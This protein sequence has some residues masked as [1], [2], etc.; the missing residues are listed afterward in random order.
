MKK[1]K[2]IVIAILTSILLW[3][4]LSL[5]SHRLFKPG[6]CEHTLKVMTYN[7]HGMMIG[8]TLSAQKEM[9]KYINTQNADIVCLQEVLV[10]NDPKLLTLETL[11]GAMS[12]Y[13][14]SYCDFKFSNNKR[15]FG[16]VIFSRYPLINQQRIP[17][18]SKSNIS[19]QCDVVVGKDTIRLIVNH[20]ESYKL[21][22]KDMKL[23]E[24]LSNSPVVQKVQDSDLLRHRQ[25]KE[26][27]RHIRKS[28]HPVIVVGDFNAIPLS[29]VYWKI[30]FGLHDCFLNGSFGK[31]GN[32]YRRGM[33]G[34]RIDFI[35]CSRDLTPIDCIV[36]GVNYSDHLPVI[37]TIGW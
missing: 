18:E 26:V 22:K 17:Y 15:Q 33:F 5:V 24:E 28:P 8:E 6:K 11:H 29:L 1:I 27:K 14:Y 31:L 32:T 23:A 35:L 37:A 10:Y 30:K 7:T 2:L 19:S 4:L 3:V 36:D 16:N 21:D 13:P 25:A 9:L 34:A 20:L 12:N